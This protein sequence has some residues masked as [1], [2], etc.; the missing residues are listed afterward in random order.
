MNEES[1]HPTIEPEL[2]ARIVALVLGEASDFERDELNRLIELRPELAAF[3]FRMQRVH[4]LLGDVGVGEFEAPGEEWQLPSDKRDAVL[5]VISGEATIQKAVANEDASAQQHGSVKRTWKWNPGH[6]AVAV[7]VAAFMGIIALPLVND[8]S[9]SSGYFTEAARTEVPQADE[10]F[11]GGTALTFDIDAEMSVA[12]TDPSQ[13][14]SEWFL[15]DHRSNSRA[16]LSAIQD[17]LGADSILPL[18]D[19]APQSAHDHFGEDDASLNLLG[20]VDVQVLDDAGVMTIRGNEADVGR[21]ESIIQKLEEVNDESRPSDRWQLELPQVKSEAIAD[22]YLTDEF[23]IVI[24]GTASRRSEETVDQDDDGLSKQQGLAAATIE[25]APAAKE[26]I[27]LPQLIAQNDGGWDYKGLPGENR[28]YSGRDALQQVD[29]FNSAGRVNAPRDDFGGQIA[30]L[31]SPDLGEQV[32]DLSRADDQQKSLGFSVYADEAALSGID[33]LAKTDDGKTTPPTWQVPGD[34]IASLER[35]RRPIEPDRTR[36]SEPGGGPPAMTEELKELS[37]SKAQPGVDDQNVTLDFPDQESPGRTDVEFDFNVQD[38]LTPALARSWEVA[39]QQQQKQLGENL[40]RDFSKERMTAPTTGVT[41]DGKPVQDESVWMELESLRLTDSAKPAGGEADKNL[42]NLF[43]RGGRG[44]GLGTRR[45]K[46][47]GTNPDSEHIAGIRSR[48]DNLAIR[49]AE[50]LTEKKSLESVLQPGGLGDALPMLIGKQVEQEQINVTAR[51]ANSAAES[52]EASIA[53]IQLKGIMPLMLQESLLSEKLGDGHPDLLKLRNKIE[54]TQEYLEQHSATE[55]NDVA[56]AEGPTNSDSPARPDLIKRYLKSLD[57]DL[58]VIAQQKRELQTKA[59]GEEQSEQNKD[60]LTEAT[61][62]KERKMKSIASFED[63]EQEKLDQPSLRFRVELPET[64]DTLEKFADKQPQKG[65]ESPFNAGFTEA[66]GRS[67]QNIAAYGLQAQ[68]AETEPGTI[69]TPQNGQNILNY[70]EKPTSGRVAGKDVSTNNSRS[71]NESGLEKL[72]PK[73]LG[74]LSATLQE[75]QVELQQESDEL[76]TANGRFENYYRYFA[77]TPGRGSSVKERPAVKRITPSAGLNESNAE[78]E[79]FSTFSLH[80]SDVSFKLALASLGRGEWPEAAK[81][82]IEEFVNAL[83]YG[84]PMPSQGERVACNV[85]Q[86]VHPF[87]QQRNLLRVSM[88]TAAAGRASTTPLRLTLLLD[89]SGSMERIDRQQTVRRAFAMLADQLTPIDQVTLISFA[90]QPRLLADKVSGGDASK[91]VEVIDNLPSEGG[92]N[93]EAAL[94]LAFEKAQEHQTP[95]AQN[96]IIL[97]TDGAVNLGNANPE[98]LS[99]M[100]TSMRSRGIAFDAAGISAE[101]LNDEVLEALTRKG[102]GRYYL[103]DSLESADGGFARQI[104]GALRPSAK[105]VKVQIEFNPKRVGRYKLLGFEKHVLKKEDFRND[106]VD[107]AE[108]AAAEA[109]VA[110]YQFEA[111]PDGEGDVGSVSV[112]FLDL[113]TGQ[114]IEHRWPIPYEADAPRSDQAAPS[115][116]IAASAALLA[117]KLRGEQLGESVDLKTLSHLMAGLPELERN[118]S[119]VQQ[120]QLMIEQARQL[121]KK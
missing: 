67:Q 37:L 121:S 63:S 101:G 114:M 61:S 108:M 20:P 82:R 5:A 115:L 93:I 64:Q 3:Q 87:L 44:I 109:G 40:N 11:T 62:E 69:A 18:G 72:A 49:E 78:Q 96:R 111:M 94:Q 73:S 46:S 14:R 35:F 106:K 30:G 41:E 113:S 120:L 43:G 98:S 66:E 116:R 91:L 8:E 4:G 95:N 90:R 33:T 86:S 50:I 103:L 71:G 74:R 25:A 45:S 19:Q 80:V 89:N 7:C 65:K 77:P 118:D 29:L 36:E 10:Q 6:V 70:N 48:I 21:V 99:Q 9:A 28:R 60:G 52:S 57:K 59:D 92:T 39:E 24:G 83:D 55:G 42:G 15:R 105:N 68:M 102:D 100:V 76:V 53:Q 110:M 1:K 88:R 58:N 117:A 17:T 13:A 79:S 26:A 104:A 2:E 84:D 31:A 34:G 85:E 22:G 107:A 119:R 54:M 51:D 23:Q 16:A 38:T 112:R 47:D 32:L 97:L 81:I 56:A 12:A 27:D 75:R